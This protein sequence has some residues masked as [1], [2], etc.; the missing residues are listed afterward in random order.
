LVA[1]LV[2]ALVTFAGWSDGG[3]ASHDVTVPATATTYT[4]TYQPS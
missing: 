4:A 2:T 3:A 1:A